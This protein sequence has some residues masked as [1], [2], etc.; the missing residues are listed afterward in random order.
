MNSWCHGAAG[1]ALSRV[2]CLGIEQAL[3]GRL[4]DESQLALATVRA[5]ASL[6]LDHLC[7]GNLGRAEILWVAGSHPDLADDLQDDARRLVTETVMRKRE[8]GGYR[9]LRFDQPVFVPGF[10]QGTAGVGYQL[11]RMASNRKFPSIL[12]GHLDTA[13]TGTI[14]S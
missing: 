1:I 5:E 2:G 6:D 10:F 4:H 13:P 8:A 11:I 3:D 7:C 9:F 14:A 12:E